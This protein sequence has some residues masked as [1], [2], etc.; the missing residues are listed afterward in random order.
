VRSAIERELQRGSIVEVAIR[1]QPLT[2]QVHIAYP[3]SCDL[4]PA[5][6]AFLHILEE[7]RGR[8]LRQRSR[9]GEGRA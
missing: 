4:S 6:T 8:T 2:L 1:D 5:A 3:D 9:G 7:E